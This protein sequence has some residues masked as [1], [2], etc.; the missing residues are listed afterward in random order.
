MAKVSITRIAADLGVSAMSVSV[1]LRGKP[2]VSEALRARILAHARKLGYKPDPVTAELMAMVR[3]RHRARGAETIAFLNTFSDPD[4]FRRVDGFMAFFRGA[5]AEAA[6]FGYRVEMFDARAKGMS[7]GRLASILKARGVRGVLVGPRWMNEPDIDFP[8]SEFSVVL[9][10][11]A[12]YGPNLNRV[13]NHHIHSC[14]TA[15]KALRD[16]GYRRIGIALFRLGE[17]RR[18]YD[19]L[20][21]LD[22]VRRV[23]FE[24]VTV[25]P[26]LFEQLDLAATEAWVRDNALDAVIA[27]SGQL[28]RHVITLPSP[29]GGRVAFAGLSLE[30]DV[31]WSGI[32][33]HLDEIGAA[34]VYLLRDLLLSGH[35]GTLPRP[36]IVLVEGEWVDGTTAPMRTD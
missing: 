32:N 11:E 21:G 16:R 2:G 31:P 6:R 12:A 18:S 22:Q 1:A 7:E 3:S 24:D 27:L 14:A 4:F 20:L 30:K 8:W 36:R 25:V 23:G 29:R 10:G 15:L 13:C 17:Q 35:R 5:K 9:V 28:G 19:Y 26:W 33:Q 34:S